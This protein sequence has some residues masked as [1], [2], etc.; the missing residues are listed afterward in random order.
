MKKVKRKLVFSRTVNNH[1]MNRETVY[2]IVRIISQISP[3][4]HIKFWK[5]FYS[6]FAYAVEVAVH[7]KNK[8]LDFLAKVV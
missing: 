8:L 6:I 1:G 4:L 7:I 5:C 2:Q 3:E